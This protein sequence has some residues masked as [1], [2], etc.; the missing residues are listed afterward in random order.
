MAEASLRQD[1]EQTWKLAYSNLRVMEVMKYQPS[2]THCLL[3]QKQIIFVL[4]QIQAYAKRLPMSE[5][6]WL[7]TEQLIS[8][9]KRKIGA[10][11]LR[12]T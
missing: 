8:E 2:I 7:K 4:N 3:Y 5:E 12:E 11:T 6:M 9:F 10:T 1:A